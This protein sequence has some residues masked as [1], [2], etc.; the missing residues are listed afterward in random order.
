MMQDFPKL[1]FKQGSIGFTM[2]E[3]FM[4]WTPVKNNI[5]DAATC[6]KK[7]IQSYGAAEGEFN[8]YNW[9]SIIFERAGIKIERETV[10]FE[11][12]G[13][14]FCYGPK[15]FLDPKFGLTFQDLKGSF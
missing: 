1:M 15:I 13:M 3:H 9:T 6:L 5:V 14:S 7:G 10:P 2:Y 8:F 4:C 11:S 12:H